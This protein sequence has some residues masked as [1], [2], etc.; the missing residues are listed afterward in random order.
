MKGKDSGDDK[1]SPGSEHEPRGSLALVLNTEIMRMPEIVRL[2]QQVPGTR[3][4]YQRA[5]VGRLMIVEG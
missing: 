4:V 2:V 3:I 5:S 1:A